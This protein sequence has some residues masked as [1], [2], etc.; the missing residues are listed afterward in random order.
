MVTRPDTTTVVC[1]GHCSTIDDSGN[2][3]VARSGRAPGSRN[4]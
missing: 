1:P 4:R 3:V 2:L